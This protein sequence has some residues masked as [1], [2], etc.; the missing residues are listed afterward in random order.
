MSKS[1][2]S[3]NDG[4]GGGSGNVSQ[5][6]V[7]HTALG[8]ANNDSNTEVCE[9]TIA[10]A[11]KCNSAPA[12]GVA[13]PCPKDVPENCPQPKDLLAGGTCRENGKPG[14]CTES[15]KSAPK[16]ARPNSDVQSSLELPKCAGAE[17]SLDKEVNCVKLVSPPVPQPQRHPMPLREGTSGMDRR[18]PTRTVVDQMTKEEVLQKSEKD[19]RT[20]PREAP[21]NN[22]ENGNPRDTH[23]TGKGLSEGGDS[24]KVSEGL[25][26]GS[27]E[28]NDAN[29]SAASPHAVNTPGAE[30]AADDHR[31]GEPSESTPQAAVEQSGAVQ[32]QASPTSTSR[33]ATEATGS[34]QPSSSPST[35]KGQ[36]TKTADSSVSP[37]WVH[38]PLL[39]LALFAVAAV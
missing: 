20:D 23:T 25:T 6:D 7:T 13:V 16:A 19:S 37:V 2:S 29:G 34:S 9:K 12:S 30:S 38:A 1:S 28:K 27:E 26:E 22:H 4:T 36:D 11:Q 17:D 8:D 32:S 33:S 24:N 3:S 5:G 35:D 21:P 10:D 14:P 31:N 18:L 39:L 15:G